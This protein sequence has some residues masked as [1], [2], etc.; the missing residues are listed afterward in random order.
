M[1]CGSSVGPAN[2]ANEVGAEDT[3]ACLSDVGPGGLERLTTPL[4]YLT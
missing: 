2:G 4:P 3:P 1:P